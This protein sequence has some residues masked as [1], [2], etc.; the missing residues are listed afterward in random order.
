MNR[1]INNK[2][3][4]ITV[5]LKRRFNLR[6]QLK[7]VICVLIILVLLLFLKILNN[8]ISDNII[9]I[10][11]NSINYKFSLKE[12]GKVVLDYGKRMLTLP[13]KA[14]TVFN[15]T[16]M[17]KYPPPTEGTVYKPFGEVK[18]LDG[19]TDFNNG[20]DIIL[21]T[22]KEP[23]SIAKGVVKKIEDRGSKGYFV[24]IEH[25]DFVTVYGYLITVYVDEG[26]QIEKDIK[27]G[28]LGTNKD[29]NKYLHFE[30]WINNSPV[31]PL[32]YIDLAVKD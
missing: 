16:N 2:F 23:V 18:Y 32:E 20:V 27:V 21:N 15:V 7:S 30:V 13:E 25:E 26:K 11:D 19:R 24:T 4:G 29:G 12:D 28:N 14:L 8:N 1:R 22:D 3:N 5:F 10:I 9:Q 31:N 17:S 6:R